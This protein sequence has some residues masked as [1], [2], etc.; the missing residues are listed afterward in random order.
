MVIFWGSWVLPSLRRSL[1]EGA[2]FIRGFRP[3]SIMG[4]IYKNLARVLAN[5][6]M[7]VLP[8]VISENQVL[9]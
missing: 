1:R 5:C 3:I 7:K 8:N 2:I 9:L 6:L 4:S